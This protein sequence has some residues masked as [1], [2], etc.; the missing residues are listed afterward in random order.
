MTTSP[1]ISYAEPSHHPIT[2]ALIRAVERLSGSDRL[3]QLYDTVAAKHQRGESFWQAALSTL[4]IGV[5]YDRHKLLLNRSQGPLVVV[6]N[7]P[8]GVVDGLAICQMASELDPNFKIIINKALCRSDLIARHM[9]PIDFSETQEA[10]ET[11]IATKR[12]AIDTLRRGGTIV[13]FPGGGVSTAPWVFGEAREFDW[14][15]FVVT[16]IQRGKA[17]VLPLYFPGQNSKLFHLASRIHVNL[18]L[19]LF[20]RE[21]IRQMESTLTPSIG[22]LIRHE[23]FQRFTNRQEVV[24]FLRE[25]VRELGARE[26]AATRDHGGVKPRKTLIARR[27]RVAEPS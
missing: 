25:T 11:N 3:E 19:S 10:I 1:R 5:C 21:T 24:D 17:N 6:A 27:E 7:H 16:L 9:L 8:F 26:R 22:D 4:K 18:R 13:I 14:K 12:E 20:V 23:E 2:R 15:L